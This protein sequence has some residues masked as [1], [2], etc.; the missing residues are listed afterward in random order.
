MSREQSSD[1]LAGAR[2]R[3]AALEDELAKLRRSVGN[4]E[5]HGLLLQTII[6][7]SD[8]AIFVKD[9]QY[10]HVFTNRKA[11]LAIGHPHDQIIGKTNDELFPKETCDLFSKN[12]REVL[13]EGK[14]VISEESP[15]GKNIYLS[16]KFPIVLPDGQT[17]LCGMAADITERKQLEQ[18]L[19]QARRLESIGRFA[20]SRV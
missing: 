10:R 1:E 13:E 14:R 3:I 8:Q 11:D 18:Q 9:S 2:E 12:D 5:Q 16:Y 7:E 6:D 19:S 15:D 20:G 17:L 4:A